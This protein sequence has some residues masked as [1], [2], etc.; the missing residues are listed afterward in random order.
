MTQKTPE[1]LTLEALEALTCFKGTLYYKQLGQW[2]ID[3]ISTIRH[4][5]SARQWMP[6]ESAPDNENVIVCWKSKGWIGEARR[7]EQGWLWAQ[8]DPC[9]YH[10]DYIYP[11]YWQPLPDAPPS[12]GEEKLTTKEGEKI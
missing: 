4:A 9:D 1:Q 7:H 8:V 11:E 10:A 2:V 12:G 3:H 6:I 5:L